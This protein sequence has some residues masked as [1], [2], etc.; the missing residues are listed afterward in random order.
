M[1]VAPAMPKLDPTR[2]PSRRPRRCISNAAGNT[3][4]MTPRWVS[5]AGR[6]ARSR[7]G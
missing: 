3:E 5:V 7:L 6:V 2:K 1:T 4:S